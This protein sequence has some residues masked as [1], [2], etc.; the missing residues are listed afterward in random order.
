MGWLR[1][2]LMYAI[3]ILVVVAVAVAVISVITGRI[4]PVELLPP[5][6]PL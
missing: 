6:L 3:G 1:V 2:G 5:R 4:D